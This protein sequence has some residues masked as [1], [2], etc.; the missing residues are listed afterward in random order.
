M[1][2]LDVFLYGFC[3]FDSICTKAIEM[4]VMSRITLKLV[5]QCHI[6]QL[7][8]QILNRSGT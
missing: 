6:F 5:I 8:K 4:V 1:F 7:C 3:Y 2:D